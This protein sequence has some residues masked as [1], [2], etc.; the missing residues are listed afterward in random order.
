MALALVLVA[1]GLAV[2][3]GARAASAAHSHRFPPQPAPRVP[4]TAH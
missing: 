2:T 4:L 1:G 3:G